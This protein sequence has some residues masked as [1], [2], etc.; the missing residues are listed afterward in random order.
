MQKKYKFGLPKVTQT[1]VSPIKKPILTKK[2]RNIDEISQLH[3]DSN[4]TTKPPHLI[5]VTKLMVSNSVASIK[6]IMGRYIENPIREISFFSDLSESSRKLINLKRGKEKA[7]YSG[8]I[9]DD[10]TEYRLLIKPD[11]GGFKDDKVEF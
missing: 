9:S 11:S 4:V 8:A 5:E 6:N 7:L 3:E 1:R 2:W 10:L